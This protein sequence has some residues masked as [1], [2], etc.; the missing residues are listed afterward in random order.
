VAEVDADALVVEVEPQKCVLC[1][2][3]RVTAKSIP[4]PSPA[5]QSREV[6]IVPL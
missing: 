6:F 1:P 2:K 3:N 5:A 4:A